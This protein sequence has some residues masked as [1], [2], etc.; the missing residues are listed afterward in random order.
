[1]CSNYENHDEIAEEDI[2]LSSTGTVKKNAYNHLIFRLTVKE[3][4]SIFFSDDGTFK[5]KASAVFYIMYET[6]RFPLK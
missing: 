6:N 3:Q 5:S 4:I 1:M 2:A